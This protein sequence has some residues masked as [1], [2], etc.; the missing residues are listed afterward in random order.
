MKIVSWI[1]QTKTT[2]YG[3][4]PSSE[5]AGNYVM[6]RAS[7][8]CPPIAILPVTEPMPLRSERPGITT[9]LKRIPPHAEDWTG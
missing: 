9:Y 6:D 3:P 2:V 7:D 4:F 1:V 8:M 5:V